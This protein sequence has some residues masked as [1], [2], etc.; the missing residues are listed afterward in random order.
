MHI[1]I[2]ILGIIISFLMIKYRHHIYR[3]S[4]PWGIVERYLG[5]GSTPTFI[6]L[7]AVVVFFVS[8]TVFTGYATNLTSGIARFF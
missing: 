7:L 5:M 3:F 1:A 2:G 4:G 8:I 6:V